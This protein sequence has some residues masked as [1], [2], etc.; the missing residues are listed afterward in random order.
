MFNKKQ[1][2]RGFTLIE[3]LVVIAIIGLLAGIVLVSLGG[4]R[5]QARDARIKGELGQVRSLAELMASNLTPPDYTQLCDAGN[6]LNQGATA[7]YGTQL[8]NLASSIDNNNGTPP[9]PVCNDSASAYCVYTTLNTTT[10]GVTNYYCVDSTARAVQTTTDP[11][12]AGLCTTS[13]FVC[14]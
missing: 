14:P 11:G 6:T 12:G 10:G 13:T 8:Q 1:G 7:P 4:A 2:S 5:D 3:L 9:E